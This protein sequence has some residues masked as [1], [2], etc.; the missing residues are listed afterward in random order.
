[1]SLLNGIDPQVVATLAAALILLFMLL[2]SLYAW[3]QTD[4]S[5]GE[6]QARCDS[7]DQRLKRLDESLHRL[8]SD[9]DYLRSQPVPA[10]SLDEAQARVIMRELVQEFHKSQPPTSR[11]REG[12]GARLGQPRTEADPTLHAQRGRGTPRP[13]VPVPPAPPPPPPLDEHIRGMANDFIVRRRT[14]AL[15]EAAQSRGL[16]LRKLRH[17]AGLGPLQDRG[18][19]TTDDDPPQAYAVVDH[20]SA[21][22]WFIPQTSGVDQYLDLFDSLGQSPMRGWFARTLTRL[23]T[24]R[25]VGDTFELDRKGEWLAEAPPA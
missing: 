24:G 1:M 22:A 25:L 8:G 3:R 15:V 10:P 20:D 16:E 2:W 13:M 21:R 11:R 18:W 14:P 9:I 4:E 23:P 7:N 5:L 12:H 19:V 17:Q 6:I